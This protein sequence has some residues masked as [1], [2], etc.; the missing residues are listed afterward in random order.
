MIHTPCLF[1]TYNLFPQTFESYLS[2]LLAVIHL[3]NFNYE[4]GSF[5]VFLGCYQSYLLNMYVWVC[6]VTYIQNNRPT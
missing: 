2:S 4:N 6:G 3:R 1:A 5:L